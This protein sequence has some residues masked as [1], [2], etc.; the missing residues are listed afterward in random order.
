[1]KKF[2]R[3]AI[4]IASLFSFLLPS[5]DPVEF[6]KDGD[7]KLTITGRSEL[8]IE[9][10]H[11][12]DSDKKQ[13]YFN[14]GDIVVFSVGVINDA[15]TILQLNGHKMEEAIDFKQDDYNDG[16]LHSFTM[17]AQD[18]V[19]DISLVSG[20]YNIDNAPLYHY[21]GWI[22]YLDEDEIQSASYYDPCV[23]IP[24]LANFDTMYKAS[25][26]EIHKLYE[27]LNNTSAKKDEDHL[28]NPGS[29]SRS[30][31][32]ET[33]YGDE[34]SI[35]AVDGYINGGEGTDFIYQLSAP[36]PSFSIV[37]YYRFNDMALKDMTVIDRMNNDKD[38][39]E[40]F[41]LERLYLLGFIIIEKDY[42]MDIN[43][44]N[45]FTFYNPWGA[46]VFRD[47]KTFDIRD[48]SRDRSYTCEIMNNL[49]FEQ[50]KNYRADVLC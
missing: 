48:E 7:Y 27:F 39:T 44:Y 49:T 3:I 12:K 21:Y 30:I 15:E 29:V 22:K 13:E 19:L 1:M 38:V 50:L 42:T 16:I 23:G 36:L 46:I 11:L 47:E 33:I 43:R 10:P 26:E 40:G 9:G 20:F 6:K 32:I 25:K 18:S 41:Y 2:K 17:P 24:S 35:H 34:Y 5:C 4:L 31:Y 14:A 8:V 37:A 28:I 45:R